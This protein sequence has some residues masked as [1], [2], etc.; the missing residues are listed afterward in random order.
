MRQAGVPTSSVSAMVARACARPVLSTVEMRARIEQELA[1]RY[2]VCGRNYASTRCRFATASDKVDQG[3]AGLDSTTA[4]QI[5]VNHGDT[6]W[7][8]QHG[9]TIALSMVILPDLT[10][11]HVR[12]N[13]SDLER[14]GMSPGTRVMV[15]KPRHIGPATGLPESPALHCGISH[16]ALTAAAAWV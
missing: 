11:D 2:P 4:A 3:Q 1:R 16:V 15:G 10:P 12:L 7:V 5:A 9:P 8:Q 6:V 13:S 14:A